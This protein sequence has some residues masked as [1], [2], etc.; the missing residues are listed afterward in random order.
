MTK[1]VKYNKIIMIFVCS[2]SCQPPQCAEHSKKNRLIASQVCGIARRFS[3]DAPRLGT[4]TESAIWCGE[5]T[6]VNSKQK[7]KRVTGSRL[8]WPSKQTASSERVSCYRP[9]SVL[10]QARS[11]QHHGPHLHARFL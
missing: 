8:S 1:N 5:N 7:P 10:P 4:G 11:G 2:L 3:A 9:D 6:P